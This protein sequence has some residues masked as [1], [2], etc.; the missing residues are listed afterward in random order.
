MGIFGSLFGKKASPQL[1]SREEYYES[2]RKAR[3]EAWKKSGVITDPP[4]YDTFVRGVESA[5][6]SRASRKRAK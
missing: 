1:P 6:R 3:D 5:K 4:P 2:M